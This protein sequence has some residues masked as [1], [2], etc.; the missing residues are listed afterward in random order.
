MSAGKIVWTEH[1][2]LRLRERGIKRADAVACILNGEII[3]QY[4][5][6]Y[7]HPACLV[8]A[9]LKNNKTI[10][11]AAGIGDGNLFII[12][13]YYPTLDKWE[14]DYKTRKAGK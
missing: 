7:P 2:A 9:A 4:P 14:S 11:A 5:D 13:V 1:L 10:H 8:S 12:T 3:E 6:A